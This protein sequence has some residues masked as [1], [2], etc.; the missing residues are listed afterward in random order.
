MQAADQ[1]FYTLIINELGWLAGL[2]GS[3]ECQE[4]NSRADYV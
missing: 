3:W 4:S 1:L 2:V